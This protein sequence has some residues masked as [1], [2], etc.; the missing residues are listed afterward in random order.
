[1]IFLND[2]RQPVAHALVP[3]QDLYKR[4]QECERG[5]QECVRHVRHI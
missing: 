2:S 1:M 3:T 5:M 4:S